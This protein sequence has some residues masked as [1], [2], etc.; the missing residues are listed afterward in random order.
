MGSGD[1]FSLFTVKREGNV[2]KCFKTFPD[3]KRI[4]VWWVI[5][6]VGGQDLVVS[7]L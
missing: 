3:V 7:I 2:S 1:S 5:S 4:K 6:L